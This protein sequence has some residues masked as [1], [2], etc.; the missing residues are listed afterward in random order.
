MLNCKKCGEVFE[1]QKGLKQYCSLK[2]RNSRAWSEE[3]RLKKSVAAKASE[4]VL[5]A[6]RLNILKARKDWTEE[7]RKIHSLRMKQTWTES[8]RKEYSN[9]QKGK[10]HSKVVVEKIRQSQIERLKKNPDLHPNR[11]CAGIKESYPERTVREFFE[12]LGYKR[13]VDFVQQF[14]VG[15]YYVDFFL[16]KT[17]VCI[18][19]DGERWHDST[20]EREK[21]RELKI[22]QT[23]KL[24]RFSAVSIIK[25]EYEDTLTKLISGS[26]V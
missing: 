10:R 11:L 12:K 20:S 5:A 14:P 7:A 3:D 16:P 18:E 4:R 8:K 17:G 25:K 22:R 9:R 15:K 13:G 26:G 21:E 23:Y 19:I 6:N 1:P 2:C 24:Y